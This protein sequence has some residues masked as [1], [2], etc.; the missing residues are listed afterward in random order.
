MPG[1][2]KESLDHENDTLLKNKYDGLDLIGNGSH[3][4]V[5]K[6]RDLTNNGASVAL[7]R[8][9][10]PNTE[11]G[12]P[13]STLREVA[14]LKQLDKH[15]HPHVVRLLDICHGQRKEKASVMY[16]VFEHM[17]QDLSR[18]LEL[19]PPPGLNEGKIKDLM[20]QIL[21]GVDFLHSNRIIHRDLK[22]QNILVAN[23]GRVKLTD[24]GLA[25]TYDYEM[26]LTTVVVTLWY[27]APEV[28]LGLPYASSVDIWSCGCIMAELYK[29]KPIFVG[30]SE[31]DQLDKIFNTMGTPSQSEWPEHCSLMWSSFQHHLKIPIQ[32]LLPEISKCGKDLLEKMLTFNP[33]QRISA[34]H[35]L[36]HEFFSHS[37]MD[38]VNVSK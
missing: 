33:V 22:P 13:I 1:S 5:Y 21:S 11:E 28:L 16:L 6:A 10:V 18:Y 8:I 32:Q 7:K 37:V 36:Q 31:G 12:I 17:D 30:T 27:R 35:A 15:E 26:R 2:N 14:M 29:L 23:D 34:L 24:F 19:C 38:D 4:W 9:V 20:Y 3:G 25:K